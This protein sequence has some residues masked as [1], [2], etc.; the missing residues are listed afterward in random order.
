MPESPVAEPISPNIFGAAPPSERFAGLDPST[1]EGAAELAAIAM[2][3]G[4]TRRPGAKSDIPAGVTYLTQFVVLDVNFPTREAAAGGPSLDLGLIYGDG[5]KHHTCSYQ[6]P[7]QAGMA[8]HLLRIGRTRPTASS[9]AWGATRDL[10]RVSCPNLDARPVESRSEVLVP[11]SASDSNLLLGQVQVL[12]TLLHN[13]LA[14][15]LA[16]SRRTEVAF[17]LA[18][19]INR[20]VYRQVVRHDVLGSWLLPAL[21]ARYA[22]AAGAELRRVPVEFTAGV[23]RLGHGLVREIY[24]LNAQTQVAGLRTL[25]RHTST[26]RP[27]EMPLTED[28][29]VDFSNFFSIGRRDPQLARA[30][31]PHV[32]RPFGAGMVPGGAATLVLR[33]LEACTRGDLRSVPSLLRRAGA[34]DPQLFTGRFGEDGRWQAALARWLTDA[35]LDPEAVGRLSQDPPLTL[36]LMLEAE[37]D[38]GGKSLGALG[39]VIMG[40]TLAAAL[41]P[42]PQDPEADAASALLFRNGAPASMAEVIRFLQ[43][44]YRFA[45]GARLHALDTPDQDDASD[46]AAACPNRVASG[47]FDMLDMNAPAHPAIPEIEV[48]DYIEMGRLVAQWS[49]DPATRPTTVQELREQLDG[50]AVVPDRIQTIEFTQSRLDHLVLAMPPREMIEGAIERVTDPLSDSRYALPQFYADHSR[51]GFGPVMTPLDTLLARVGDHTIAQC[52]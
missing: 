25:L 2:R 28:W 36:F 49:A 32:P 37:A 26:G 24:T 7:F 9:P 23:G 19:R 6:V 45:E 38:A 48:A 41:G 40:E 34:A 35:G 16:E 47:G 39:S 4:N 29:L 52:R 18:R 14:A 1:V 12:W 31:G 21:R 44:H 10:P 20:A 11:D 5:P 46:S 51:P 17:D 27:F 42:E 8:R 43:S 50:V 13:A 15:T 3:I 22:A 30:L 33:D